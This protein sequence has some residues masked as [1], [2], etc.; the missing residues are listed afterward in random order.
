[1]LTVVSLVLNAAAACPIFGRRSVR[2]HICLQPPAL[3]DFTQRSASGLKLTSRHRECFNCKQRHRLLCC[4]SYLNILACRLVCA[5]NRRGGSRIFEHKA[6]AR[7][8]KRCFGGFAWELWNERASFENDDGD[9]HDDDDD[10]IDDDV[11]DDDD[12]VNDD[13]DS[14]Q[15]NGY[16]FYHFFKRRNP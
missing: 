3:L 2:V 1:M 13:D 9:S 11:N 8:K 12:D 6:I 16:A 15:E 4:S 7:I 14:D 5:V 10:G